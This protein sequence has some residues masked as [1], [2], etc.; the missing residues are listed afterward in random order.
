MDREILFRR[1]GPYGR[2][3]GLRF[4]NRKAPAMPYAPG[5]CI[6]NPENLESVNIISNTT[7]PGT[8]NLSPSSYRAEKELLLRELKRAGLGTKQISRVTGCGIS[9]IVKACRNLTC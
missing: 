5:P 1:S 9:T 6:E 3:Q 2:L 7:P 8:F 4:R